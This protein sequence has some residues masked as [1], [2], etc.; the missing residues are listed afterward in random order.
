MTLPLLALLAFPA[1]AADFPVHVV[2]DSDSAIEVVKA[3]VNLLPAGATFVVG[4]NNGSK[5][6]VVPHLTLRQLARDGAVRSSNSYRLL[7]LGTA[8]PL[9]V[10]SLDMVLDDIRK[11]DRF[12]LQVSQAPLTDAPCESFCDLCWERAVEQCDSQGAQISSYNCTCQTD[13]TRICSWS[14]Y[15]PE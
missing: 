2:P 12:E 13:G 8:G 4:L 10:Q 1:A 3:E 7:P 5:V 11:G 14:C 6:E 9:R 15:A